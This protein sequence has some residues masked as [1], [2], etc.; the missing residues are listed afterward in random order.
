MGARM[1]SPFSPRGQPFRGSLGFLSFAPLGRPPF[2]PF[3][4]TASAFLADFTLPPL[5]P[6]SDR[7]LR[8]AGFMAWSMPWRL[9]FS[10]LTHSKAG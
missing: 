10:S 8:I 2:L 3:R 7:Y 4:R 6:M 5:A 1:T 9:W